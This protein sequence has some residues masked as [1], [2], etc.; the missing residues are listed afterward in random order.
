MKKCPRCDHDITDDQ[1]YCPHC[2]LDLQRQYQPIRKKNNNKS[3]TYLIY[4]IIFFSFLTIP[5]LYSQVLSNVSEGLMTQSQDGG[6]LQ[7]ILDTDPTIVVQSFDTLSDYNQKYSNVSTYVN[8]I[9]EYEESL[10]E[11]GDYVFNKKY[12]IQVLDN[13]NVLY[14]LT[15]TTSILDQ[16]EMKIVKEFDRAH[17]FHT[18]E[19]TFQKKNAQSFEELLFN[20]EEKEMLNT[21]INDSTTI[22]QIM[23]DFSLRKDEF[24][25]KK[26]KLGHY[27]LG[28]YQDN[29]SFVVK[30]YHQSY[31]SEFKYQ[32]D[33][34]DYIA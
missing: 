30:R 10:S 20:E 14:Q 1:K 21:F 28:T 7:D 31:I 16:Y 3:M 11:K 5:L 24:E 8:N 33:V 13:N 4:V 12:L 15:Y 29:A 6:K 2:G 27:G 9:K 25:L 32:H 23:N 17:S 26:E 18:E 22:D 19:I 34:K